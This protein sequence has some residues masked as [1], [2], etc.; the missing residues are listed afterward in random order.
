MSSKIWQPW[1]PGGKMD[2]EI[3]YQNILIALSQHRGRS[4]RAEKWQLVERIFRVQIPAEERNAN[5][6][7][8]RQFRR[9]VSTLRH[10][11]LLIGSDSRGGY[12]LMEDIAEVLAVADQFRHR[13]HD[14]LHSASKLESTGRALYSIQM[15]LFQSPGQTSPKRRDA[16]RQGSALAKRR[17][18]CQ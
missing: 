10:N 11:G 8:D 4:N 5:N 1:L 14:L 15:R 6:P 13:A 9:A 12:W 7:Y 3:L 16:H 17:T 2:N 18:P